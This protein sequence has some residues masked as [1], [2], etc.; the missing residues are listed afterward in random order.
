MAEFHQVEGFVIDRNLGLNHLI[1]ILT[2]F[3]KKI[4]VEK[5][6]LKPTYNPY[7]EPSMEIFGTFSTMQAIIPFSSAK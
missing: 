1:G 3:Y 6:W 4:G 7:T 2:E 5:I